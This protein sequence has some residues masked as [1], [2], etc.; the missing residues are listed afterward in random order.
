MLAQTV[1][2][3]ASVAVGNLDSL[4]STERPFLE[5]LAP[6]LYDEVELLI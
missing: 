3:I 2:E 4:Q 5:C 6:L 1:I